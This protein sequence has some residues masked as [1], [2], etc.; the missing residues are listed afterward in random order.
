MGRYTIASAE[1]GLESFNHLPGPRWKVN[2]V[3]WAGHS[4][5]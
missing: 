5:P 2:W 1:T 3:V 4:W